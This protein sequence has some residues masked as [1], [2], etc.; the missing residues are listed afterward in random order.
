MA[1]A[2]VE[3]TANLEGD[4]D[5]HGLLA[6]IA[7]AMRESGIFPWG[8]I[9]VRAIKLDDYF[10]ADG[11]ED[12]AFINITVTMGAGRSAEIKREFFGALF[13]KIKMHFAELYRHRYLAISMYVEE[14]DENASFK[15]NNLH[16]RFKKDR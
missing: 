16:Q 15:H 13:E 10:I 9:R 5:I 8:G 12:D 1:H 14:A 11:K 2:T 6:L 3:W 4:A 7:A